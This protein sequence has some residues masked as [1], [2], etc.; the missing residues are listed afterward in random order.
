[1]TATEKALWLQ[2]LVALAASVVVTAMYPFF[3][4]AARAGFAVMAIAAFAGFFFRRTGT[5]IIVDERDQAIDR[6]ARNRGLAA[7]AF[8]LFIGIVITV[9]TGSEA[10]PVSKVFLSW[11]TWIAATIFILVKGL[12]GVFEY[13]KDRRASQI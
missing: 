6:T 1:M 5:S 8:V 2:L 3:G 4:D 11:L 12:V 13:R 7:G 9:S 10:E